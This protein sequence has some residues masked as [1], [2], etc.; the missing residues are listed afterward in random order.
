M[1]VIALL[2]LLPFLTGCATF[3]ASKSKGPPARVSVYRE[4]SSRDSLFPMHFSVDGRPIADLYPDDERGFDI[5]PGPHR[6]AY[7]LGV[8]NCAADVRLEPGES[9]AYRLARGCI[10]DQELDSAGR[11]DQSFGD[12]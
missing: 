1:K 5:D 8:Y 11:N 9:Y 7:E 4:P 6:F 3:E 2:P 12:R 10:I